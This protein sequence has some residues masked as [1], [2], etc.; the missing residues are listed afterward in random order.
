MRTVR[1]VLA[2]VSFFCFI[3]AVHAQS[4]IPKDMLRK[5]PADRY[6]HRL[7][8]GES[9]EK[10]SE[11]SRFEI[12]KYFESKI[13]GETLVHEWAQSKTSRGKTLESH[14][15]ELSNTII[16]S[17]SRDIPGIE[18]A[19]TKRNRRAK[20]YEAWAVLEKSKYAA[21]LSE[22][23]QKID[24]NVDGRLAKPQ[25]SD[26]SLLRVY[27][28]VISELVLREQS[29]QDLFLLDSG[30]AVEP[31]DRL[32]NAVMT[33][34]D[35][36]ISDGFDVGIVFNGEV[37]N[38]VKSGIISGIVNAGIRLSEY[39]DVK[40]SA[41][42]GSDLVML[43]EHNVSHRIAKFRNREFFNVDWVLSVKAAVPSTGKVIDALVQNDKLAGAQS[44]SQAENRMVKKI[45]ESE[46]PVITSWVYKVIFKP[47]E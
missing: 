14:L 47:E 38:N 44:E 5:Y 36:L 6:I 29:M 46:V 45:L 30:M 12:A 35:S 11:A 21:V 16:V 9:A 20:N 40:S 19:S 23:I 15:T 26:L 27:T 32:L 13:S 24:R 25:E 31:R 18:I 39:P 28:G 42:S 34:L 7:G 37:K 3:I 17:A 2:V 4:D 1:A 22:R 8:T 41:D 33:S 43:V 10:A